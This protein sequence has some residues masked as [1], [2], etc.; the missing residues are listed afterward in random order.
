MATETLSPTPVQRFYDNNNSPAAAAQIF[1]YQAGTTTKLATYTSSSGSI[2]NTNPIILNARGECNLWIPPN[3]AYKF[4]FAPA[5]DTDPPTNPF[6]T[7]DN[8]VNSQLITLYGGVDTGSANNYILNF[9]A[10]FTSYVDGL[11]IY[12]VPANNNTS[13]STVNVNGLGAV[14]IINADGTPIYANQLL[15]NQPSTMIYY[16]GSFKLLSSINRGGFNAQRITTAQ[17]FNANTVTTLIFNSANTNEGFTAPYGTG[18]GI[19]TAPVTG[20]YIFT[21]G[22][23]LQNNGVSNGVLNAIYFSK[24]NATAIGASRFDFN[25]GIIQQGGTVTAASNQWLTTG[26][27]VVQ[28]NVGDTMRVKLDLGATW[29]AGFAA[30]NIGSTFSGVRIE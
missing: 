17:T 27:M 6:W 5:T 13:A 3:T 12:W 9:T 25:L 14:N 29:T 8:I 23:F 19:Y 26:S 16:S 7:V 4:V 22:V 1:T 30:F 2:A 11:V 28:M 24:N 21:G 15:A 20:F 18:T 10:P